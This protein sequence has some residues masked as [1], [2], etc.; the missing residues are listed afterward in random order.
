M[1]TTK[2]TKEQWAVSESFIAKI[3]EDNANFAVKNGR[4]RLAHTETYG[5]QQNVNDTERIR[6][7][8]KKAGFEFT[9]NAEE[10]DL[11]IY[12]TC[13]V[14]ENAEQRVFGRLGI[15][16]HIKENTNPD[17]MVAVCGCMVQQE[18]ITEKIKKVHDHVDLIFGTHSLWKMPELLYKTMTENGVV[19]D[20]TQSDGSIAEDVPILRDKDEKAWVSI[21]YGCNNFCTYCIVPYVRGRER[22]RKPED[23]IAEVKCLVKGGTSEISLLGQNV[24]SYG[25]D[26][27]IDIDF[28][29]LIRMINDIDGVE[30]IRFMTSH[31]KDL[32]DKLI[33]TMRD[34]EHVCK[35]LHLP[36]QAGSDKI[37]KQ[38]NRRYT[39]EKYL[40]LID[41]VKKEIPGIALTTDV[42]V[43]FP[44]ETV[45]DFKE[46]LDIIKYVRFDN[47]F[48]FIYSRREGTPAAKLDFVLT[49][50]E[51]HKNFNELLEVQNQICLEKNLEYE[52]RVEKILVDGRSKTNKSLMAGRTDSGKIVNFEGTEDMLGK[53]VDVKIVHAKQWSLEGEILR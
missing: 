20:I 10:A 45:E 23:I 40:S 24:N 49:D 50:E 7:M 16:K 36:F 21:M 52:G 31:P 27:D 47:I 11:V 41:K 13:A 30:R 28:A 34:C 29:D 19:V 3:K 33:Y 26:L 44:T 38:M 15:L 8:L 53:Y 2:I 35:Q 39:K 43:G 6:G 46:T 18:H 9:D 42:I 32:S 37:L 25:K 51:I 14:R 48:S 12:N 1:A 5:C 22:S 4:T 17:M